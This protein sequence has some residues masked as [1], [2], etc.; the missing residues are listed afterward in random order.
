[1]TGRNE[2]N[3]EDW[4]PEEWA[5]ED[6]KPNPEP[7]RRWRPDEWVGDHG[8]GRVARR[9]GPAELTTGQHGISGYG[10]TVPASHWVPSH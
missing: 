7:E 8:D 10:H 1:M 5:G 4:V 3:Y 9:M 2:R 6:P